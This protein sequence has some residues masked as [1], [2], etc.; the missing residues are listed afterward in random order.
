MLLFDGECHVIFN[1]SLPDTSILESRAY[2]TM[3]LF[4]DLNFLIFF[5][6]VCSQ[7]I[8]IYVVLG[9]FHLAFRTSFL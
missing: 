3:D 6:D 8:V 7:L 4:K 5:L 9:T 1:F 2:F